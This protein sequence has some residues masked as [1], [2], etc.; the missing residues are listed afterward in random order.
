MATTVWKGHLTFG[1]IRCRPHVCRAR[2]NESVSTSSTKSAI[3]ASST[4]VLSVCNRNV[5]APKL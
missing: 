2:G 3:R 5:N 1:L 4:L